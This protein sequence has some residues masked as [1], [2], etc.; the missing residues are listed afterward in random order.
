MALVLLV[1]AG[2]MIRTFQA[3]R[4]VEPGFTGC[5]AS[6]NHANLIPA[7]LVAGAGTSH[8]N[9]ERNLD[10]LAAIPGVTSAGFASE[11][12]MEG[13]GSRL[14]RN[15]CRGQGLCGQRHSRR[16][17]CSRYVSPGFF[18]TAGTR[19]VAGREI[20]WT[21]V[22]GLRPVVMIS[23]N[24]ARELW[25]TPSAAI[26]KRLREFPKM[27][28]H[29][30][31]GVVQDVRENGVQEKA[32]AIVYWPPMMDN[33][34]GPGPAAGDANGDIRGPQR[35]RGHGKFSEPGSAGR[36]VGEFESAAGVGAD[37][38]GGLRPIAGANFLHAGDAGD[39]GERWRWC[40]ASS[41]S[42]A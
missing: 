27:P 39:C 12:P 28:W 18:H 13:F 36:V 22:Y 25:G 10:K 3:L 21:E 26:G 23:E 5:G 1:S 9:A 30:V 20:T 34:F 33:L 6:A 42:M 19:M 16:C 11:M 2:L 15:L 24:L 29:E 35:A 32:P 41:A 7:S 17:G 4:T 14:G 37:D 38:A 31:I 40:W 8:A